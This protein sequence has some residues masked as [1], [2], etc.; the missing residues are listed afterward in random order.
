MA[1]SKQPITPSNVLAPA[2]PA[3]LPCL[4][5]LTLSGILGYLGVQ[6]VKYLSP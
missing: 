1:G 2:G 6:F 3:L 5:M 4:H